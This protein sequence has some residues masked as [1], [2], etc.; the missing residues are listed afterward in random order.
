MVSHT[1]PIGTSVPMAQVRVTNW[2][3]NQAT[4]QLPGICGQGLHNYNRAPEGHL[5]L[6]EVLTCVKTSSLIDQKHIDSQFTS[7]LA[8]VYQQQML[9]IRGIGSGLIDLEANKY[10]TYNPYKWTKVYF[11]QHLVLTWKAHLKLHICWLL[12]C[13]EIFGLLWPHQTYG[14]KYWAL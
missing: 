5:W 1:V 8:A 2:E 4:W 14:I 11:L 9:H 13:K 6:F 7:K 12:T 3:F 10:A